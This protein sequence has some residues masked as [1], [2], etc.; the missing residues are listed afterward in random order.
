MTQFPQ[1]ATRAPARCRLSCGF[2]YS[3]KLPMKSQM[4]QIGLV[5]TYEGVARFELQGVGTLR[6]EGGWG[7]TGWEGATASAGD[8]SWQFV[9]VLSPR[10][11]R[12][13]A[14]ATELVD[15]FLM[16]TGNMIGD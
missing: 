10:A 3:R 8:A 16:V 1:K 15:E 7:P 4:P 12:Y 11:R 9:G 14:T 2:G 13:D 5:P 6:T